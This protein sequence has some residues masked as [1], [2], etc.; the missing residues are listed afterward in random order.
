MITIIKTKDNV[1]NAGWQYAEIEVTADGDTCRMVVSTPTLTGAELQ[2]YCD[3][4]EEEYKLAALKAMYQDAYFEDSAGKT[5]L[6]KF[7]S[8]I[9]SGHTNPVVK[10][11]KDTEKE[12]PE[13]IIKKVAWVDMFGESTEIEKLASRVKILETSLSAAPIATEK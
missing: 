9:Q 13:G 10:D 12:Y 1:A 2:A 11:V 5:D 7:E 8:W 3:A 4:R 6:E